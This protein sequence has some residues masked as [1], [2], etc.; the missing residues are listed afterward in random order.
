MPLKTVYSHTILFHKV[1]VILTFELLAQK[2]IGVF[3]T[4][5]TFNYVNLIEV[6]E[7][8]GKL[9]TET[10]FGRIDGKTNSILHRLFERRGQI[11]AIYI[12]Q[13]IQHN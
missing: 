12:L 1:C 7:G 3:H 5:Q 10:N 9:R 8:V 4:L 6:F 11:A 2:L 13:K